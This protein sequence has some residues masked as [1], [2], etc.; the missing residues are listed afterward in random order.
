MTIVMDEITELQRAT[1]GNFFFPNDELSTSFRLR[2]M[3]CY[4]GVR[5]EQ[6]WVITGEYR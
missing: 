2:A 1:K 6:N 4:I 3:F 5:V